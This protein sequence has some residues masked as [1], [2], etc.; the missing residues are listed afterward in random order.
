MPP[1]SGGVYT[2]DSG[3]ANKYRMGAAYTSI[4]G[5]R[6][7]TNSEAIR[8]NIQNKFA[9]TVKYQP[10]FEVLDRPVQSYIQYRSPN[11][12]TLW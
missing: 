11:A 8:H 7:G 5:I 6:M 12:Y 1:Y 2:K 4:N 3:T 9:H 10:W